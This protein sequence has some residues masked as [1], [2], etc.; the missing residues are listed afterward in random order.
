MEKNSI[1]DVPDPGKLVVVN[2]NLKTADLEIAQDIGFLGLGDTNSYKP[3]ERILTGER[4]FV[5]R[6]LI[7]QE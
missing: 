7:Q 2:Y 4:H 3:A 5:S 6:K 1:G